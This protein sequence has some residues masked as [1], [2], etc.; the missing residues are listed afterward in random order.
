M[1]N[2]K[3]QFLCCSEGIEIKFLNLKP[4]RPV[5]MFRVVEFF[6]NFR[7]SKNAPISSNQEV[8]YGLRKIPKLILYS[9]Y[10][11]FLLQSP[12]ILKSFRLLFDHISI[13]WNCNVH[14]QIPVYS[15]LIIADYGVR[16]VVSNASDLLVFACWFHLNFVLLLLSSCLPKQ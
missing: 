12:Y 7:E 16:F 4:W 11:G 3:A 8:R 6:E 14:W 1:A 13:S 10:A 2:F 9:T 15:F 5:F